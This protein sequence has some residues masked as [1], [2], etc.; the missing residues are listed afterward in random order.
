[1]SRRIITRAWALLALAATVTLLAAC[2][3]T[4][5]TSPRPTTQPSPRASDAAS[6]PVASPTPSASNTAQPSEAGVVGENLIEP[7]DPA[8]FGAES[9]TVTNPWLPLRPGTRWVFEG[10]ATVDD[11]RIKRRIVLVI[12]DLRKTIAGITV[13]VGFERDYD[14]GQLVESE[15][16]FWA[17]DDKGVVWR[18]GEYP[19]SYEDGKIVETPVWLHGFEGAAAGIAMRPDPEVYGP[20]YSQGWGPAVGWADRAKAFEIGSV[21]CVPIDCYEDVLVMD[22]F[23]RDEPDAH[24]LKYYV[25]DVG[26]VRVGWAGAREEEQETMGLVSFEQ[27]SAAN[28]AAVRK[29]ALAQ[30]ARGYENSPEVYGRTPR[31]VMVPID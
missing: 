20:S 8:S 5:V 13:V 27:L 28:L 31:A 24:Q 17:Q 4:A 26:L 30:E 22:E 6:T 18:L 19:E 11:A 29:E 14:A 9:A 7:F 10:S 15:L 1:M 3:G 21:T 25:R 2:T 16:A 12:T 23:S